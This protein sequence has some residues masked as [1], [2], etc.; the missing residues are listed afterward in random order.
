MGPRKDA[1]DSSEGHTGQRRSVQDTG[2][3]HLPSDKNKIPLSG[4][5]VL[6]ISK[7][8][9]PLEHLSREASPQKHP[10]KLAHGAVQL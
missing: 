8:W 2:W 5:S 7:Q 1:K 4:N 3:K 9:R 6:L 10:N